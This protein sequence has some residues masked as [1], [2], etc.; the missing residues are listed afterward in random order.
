MDVMDSPGEVEH[1]ANTS[2]Q[3]K[4]QAWYPNEMFVTISVASLHHAPCAM[5]H[6]KSCADGPRL[7]Q[8][9]R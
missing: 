3:L 5:R 1:D 4:G 7:A 2:M 9:S 6:T 8:C